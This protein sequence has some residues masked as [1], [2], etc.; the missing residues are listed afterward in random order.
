MNKAWFDEGDH[1]D[2]AY[3]APPSGDCFAC[4]HLRDSATCAIFVGEA[5]KARPRLRVLQDIVEARWKMQSDPHETCD[6]FG[7]AGP[8]ELRR[9]SAR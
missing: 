4:I 8:V 3:M 7:L 1:G 6:Y 5:N 2:G 9:R